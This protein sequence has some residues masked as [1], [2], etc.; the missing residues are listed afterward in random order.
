MA[1]E[2][3]LKK[4][5]KEYQPSP[6]NK[7]K[8]KRKTF[9]KRAMKLG[10]ISWNDAEKIVEENILELLNSRNKKD[11][12]YATKYFAEFVKPKKREHTGELKEQV[13]V[14]INYGKVE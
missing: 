1:N 13:V 14:Q 7:R 2:Q 4:F 8:P 10:D 5:S 3:N 6:A 11:R 12:M 9:I